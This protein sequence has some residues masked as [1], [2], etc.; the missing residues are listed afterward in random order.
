MNPIHR[1]FE[2]I[3]DQLRRQKPNRANYLEEAQIKGLRGIRDLRVPLPFP[4]MALAGENGCGKTTVLFALACAYRLPGVKNQDFRPSILFPDFRPRDDR[5]PPELD[6][7]AAIRDER[8]KTELVFS[9]VAKQERL[10]MRWSRNKSWNRSFFGR[11]DGKQ[12]ERTIYLRTLANLSSPSEVRSVLQL[13]LREIHAY[14]VDAA[15]I[16]FAQSI[17]GFRY[18]RLHMIEEGEKNLLF[19]QRQYGDDPVSS[20]YSEFH[21]SAGE[22]AVLRLSIDL[23]QLTD[24]LVLIDEV[25]AGLHPYV[26]QM[27]MLELERLALRNNLQIVVTTHSPIVLDAVPPEARVF[28]ARTPS[29]VQRLE[30]YRDIIQRALY[31]HSEHVL[32]ILCED[33]DAEALLRG[34]LDALAPKIGFQQND[35]VLGRDTGKDQFLQHLEALGKFRKLRD[36]LF[37]LDGDGREIGPRMQARAEK[38]GQNANVLFL[39]GNDAPE[40]W[41]WKIIETHVS[42][43]AP[44][45]G[46]DETTL[47]T[48][49]RRIEDMFANAVDKPSA[50]AKNKLFALSQKANRDTTDLL[51]LIGRREVDRG[52]L[53]RLY[54]ELMDAINAWRSM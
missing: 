42:D 19:A 30:P 3:W 46:F 4:V 24:A 12:P 51:R 33:E 9:Y 29:D 10:S 50:I 14:E 35:I 34:I 44:E 52:D 11:K 13:A 49:M 32:S 45:L 25:E 7:I 36:V 18:A 28:L 5:K 31:G 54:Q 40:V 16:T 15:N 8:A 27:L 47:R 48:E 38:M 22:R 39:P 6:D 26:Q 41:A 1:N 20:G 21:M 17:L 2:Q 23:S 53:A 43:Y 37:V